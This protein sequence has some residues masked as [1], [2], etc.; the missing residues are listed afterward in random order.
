MSPEALNGWLESY[1][2]AWQRKD[3]VAFSELFSAN[4]AYY[5]GPFRQPQRGRQAIASAVRAAFS[6]QSEVQ[7]TFGILAGSVAP[8]V[9]HWTCEFTRISSGRR[10][11]VDGIFVLRFD[12][13][14]QCEEFREWW[15]SD[16]FA[17]DSAAAAPNNSPER[18]RDE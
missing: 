18:A 6:G 2:Q 13:Q 3:P 4:A 1:R 16:E 5:W 15:H 9:A 14:G 11:L 12:D 17:N 7:F 8:F 10:V